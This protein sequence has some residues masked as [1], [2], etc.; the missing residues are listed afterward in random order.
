M[1]G[2]VTAGLEVESCISGGRFDALCPARLGAGPQR[3]TCH[4]VAG[5]PTQLQY[6]TCLVQYL[7]SHGRSVQSRRLADA[8]PAIPDLEERP[9]AALKAVSEGLCAAERTA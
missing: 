4:M 7:H 2:S 8:S 9:A 6:C 3:E 1:Q 5:S